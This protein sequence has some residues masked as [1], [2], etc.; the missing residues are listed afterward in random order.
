MLSPQD[1]AMRVKQVFSE[2]DRKYEEEETQRNALDQNLP[3]INLYGFPQDTQALSLVSKEQAQ[4]L[5]LVVFYKEGR[6]LKIGIL[7]DSAQIDPIIQQ[8][9]TQGYACSLYIISKSSFNHIFEGYNKILQVKHRS[10]DIRLQS[11]DFSV[12]S[13]HDVADKFAALSATEIIDQI[14]G[15][16]LKLDASDIHLEP[17]AGS[18]KVRFRIDGVLQE[19]ASLL[20]N[21]HHQIVSRI[22]ILSKLKL[23]VTA[24]AQDGSFGLI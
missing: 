15:F 21:L 4:A 10:D 5:G 2:L 14:I 3:Y 23:N 17:E 11:Q 20:L 6:S 9:E 19:A 22:K 12:S 13:L 1:K 18:L 24:T 16:A 7:D 8:L